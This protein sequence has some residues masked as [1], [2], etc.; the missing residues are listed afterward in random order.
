MIVCLLMIGTTTFAQLKLGVQ[1]APTISANRVEYEGTDFDLDSDGTGLRMVFGPIVDY[2]LTDN[3]YLSSGLLFTSK[4]GA[5]EINYPD[6]TK[7]TEEYKLHYIQLPA[8]MKLFTNE[9]ALDKKIFFQFGG[10][11]DF[12][13]Q[14]EPE[15][16]DN[17]LV[18]D[19]FFM[20][21]SLIAGLGLEYQLGTSTIAFAGISYHRG[22]INQV[23][24]VGEFPADDIT[25]KNDYIGFNFGVK[26]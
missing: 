10:S 17:T 3:Y 19:F 2:Q 26:F 23:D 15:N 8:T 9:V 11:F 13:I 16:T 20:D 14:E 18:K 21:V 6:G 24:E 4:R 7:G 5:F 25:L 22:L 1:F 12:N